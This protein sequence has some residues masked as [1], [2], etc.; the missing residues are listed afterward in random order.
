MGKYKTQAPQDGAREWLV[1]K[2]VALIQ[3]CRH[4]A[5][6]GTPFYFPTSGPDAAYR[7]MWTRDFCY[8]VQGCPEA[9]EVDDI[10]RAF[11]QLIA[12]QSNDGVMPDYVTMEGKATYAVLGAQPVEDNAQFMVLL[13]YEICDLCGDYEVFKKHK[14]ALDA[15]MASIARNPVTGLVWIDPR[16]PHSSYGFTDSIA[17]TG[18]ELFCSLLFYDACCKMAT[19]CGVTGDSTT[20]TRYVNQSTRIRGNLQLLWNHNEELFNAATYDCCQPDVW[21]SAFAVAT[22]AVDAAKASA[23]SHTLSRARADIIKRGQVRHTVAP[24]WQR[25]LLD[26]RDFRNS[27]RGVSARSSFDGW[28]PGKYQNGAYWATATAWTALAIRKTNP[29]LAQAVMNELV[30]DFKTNGV[31]EC[32]NDGYAKEKDYVASACLPLLFWKS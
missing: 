27:A 26:A 11:E 28:A 24:C 10:I 18:D 25:L 17:K 32:V 23:I 21:G 4:D 30:T 31:Y 16:D 5:D 14:K 3:G 7:A 20:S 15:G 2:A 6:D 29:A 1:E 22:D 12:A 19:M 8:M 13:A 9:F